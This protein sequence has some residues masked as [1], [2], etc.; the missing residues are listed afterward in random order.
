M[1]AILR[2]GGSADDLS[3][4]NDE[5]LVREIA[6]SK[7][8]VITG[9]G[10]EVDESL[11]DL[12]ADVRAS[13]PSNAAEMLT[14]DRVAELNKLFRVMRR[15]E[16]SLT[17]EIGEAK[18]SIEDKVDAMRD[19]T[20]GAIELA[21]ERNREQLRRGLN[22]VNNKYIEPMLKLNEEK[23][24]KCLEKLRTE[25]NGMME[26]L[27][28]KLKLLEVLNPEKVLEQGYAILAGKISPGNVVKI[29]T[30]KQEIE[31]EVKK[32]KERS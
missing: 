8:P 10:H 19:K 9:I 11:A 18:S 2:G 16:Q 25:L 29:T 21:A 20:L 30:F 17:Q 27:R 28:Q 3:C 12:A 22:L 32:V 15:A 14:R 31:A 7:I 6:A 23:T 1:I 4:F 5:K 13:T 24:R 26:V